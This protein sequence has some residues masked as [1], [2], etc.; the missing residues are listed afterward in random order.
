MNDVLGAIEKCCSFLRQFIS[1]DLDYAAFKEGMAKVIGP[2]DPLEGALDGLTRVQQM[3][4]TMYVEWQGGEFGETEHLIPRRSDWVYGDS[5][6]P[7][8]W[9]D[10][11]KY[12]SRL[13]AAFK[14]VLDLD[15]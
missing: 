4:A 3:E 6:E 14:E 9:V 12:R 10:L 11:D 5:N 13:Q 8:G 7:Y 15:T 2:L 1:A